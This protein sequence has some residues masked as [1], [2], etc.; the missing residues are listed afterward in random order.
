M[1]FA[2]LYHYE[3][4]TPTLLVKEFMDG[5]RRLLQ[6]CECASK[7]ENCIVQSTGHRSKVRCIGHGEGKSISIIWRWSNICKARISSREWSSSPRHLCKAASFCPI[8]HHA[9]SQP[10]CHSSLR[11]NKVDDK[12]QYVHRAMCD[13]MYVVITLWNH[14]KQNDRKI[15]WACEPLA[16]CHPDHVK[17]RQCTQTRNPGS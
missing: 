2:L 16:L 9:I 6:K 13:T 8:I 7:N 3:P 11:Q 17:P 5:P 14:T 1:A 4:Y 12:N 10:S 15:E